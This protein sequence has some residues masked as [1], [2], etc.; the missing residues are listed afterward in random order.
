MQST[1]GNYPIKQ[2]FGGMVWKILFHQIVI[3]FA[4]TCPLRK[5]CW[6]VFS[7]AGFSFL[8]RLEEARTDIPSVLQPIQATH[9]PHFPEIRGLSFQNIILSLFFP[10]KETTK[11]GITLV[12]NQRESFDFHQ[13]TQL[14]C[15]YSSL[16]RCIKNQ[17]L[18]FYARSYSS[19]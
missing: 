2:G 1:G 13:E 8:P 3:V 16:E 6:G 15:S 19:K 4:W 17:W 12:W 7:N 10:W 5:L 9:Q 11:I 14:F 18:N